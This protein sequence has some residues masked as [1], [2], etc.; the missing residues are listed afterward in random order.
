MLKLK[1]RKHDMV[2]RV[3]ISVPD[4]LY[5]KMQKWRKEFNFSQVFQTAMSDLIEKKE[6]FLN[7]VKE[8]ENMEAIIERLKKQKADYQ[9]DLNE[10]GKNEG[11]SF[12]KSADYDDLIYA[13]NAR[14]YDAWD[15][16]SQL[17]DYWKDTCEGLEE[18]FGIKVTDDLGE[19]TDEF[20]EWFEGWKEGVE[21]FWGEVE[22]KL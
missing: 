19:P 5:V 9:S 2:Q 18:S 7:R 16:D 22:D 6:N 20:E 4:D 13:L 14:I 17:E 21:A 12:A 11:L 15:R 3:T 8:T 1:S 10:D